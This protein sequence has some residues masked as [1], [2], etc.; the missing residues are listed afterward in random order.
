MS[1]GVAL[2]GA[3]G[4]GASLVGQHQANQANV[5]IAN[6]N[7][8]FQERMSNTA[9]QR[10]VADLKAAGLNPILSAGGGASSPSGSPAQIKNVA[11]GLSNSAQSAARTIAELK[12]L[13]AQTKNV[14][15][16]TNMTDAQTV[17]MQ[18]IADSVAEVANVVGGVK[19][20]GDRFRSGVQE[21]KNLW[22]YN[23]AK[24]KRYRDK[25]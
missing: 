25:N 3:L 4:A 20:V 18:V 8:A 16:K 24:L 23:K 5:G 14:N 15:A 13:K 10:E 19:A 22:Q 21:S 2:A 17:P 6:A 9:H 12:L 1:W 7:R 11:E